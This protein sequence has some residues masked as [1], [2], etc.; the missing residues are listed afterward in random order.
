[1]IST[2]IVENVEDELFVVI[3]FANGRFVG[4]NVGKCVCR[5]LTISC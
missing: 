5:P 1:M 4:E 2:A 3:S